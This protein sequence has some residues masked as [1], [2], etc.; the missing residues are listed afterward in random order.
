M[1]FNA[2]SLESSLASTYTLCT[3]PLEQEEEEHAMCDSLQKKD[4][5][6]QSHLKDNKREKKNQLNSEEMLKLKAE[7]QALADDPLGIQPL[8]NPKVGPRKMLPFPG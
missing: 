5:I 1:L 4:W 2:L 3:Q 7:N 6:L 8:F